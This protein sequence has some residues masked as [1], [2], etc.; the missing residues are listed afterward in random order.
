MPKDGYNKR[1]EYS[2][3][4]TETLVRAGRDLLTGHGLCLLSS[5][6]VTAIDLP[7]GDYGNQWVAGAIRITW[8]LAHTSG[9]Y[10][11]GTCDMPAIGSR[12]RPPDKAVSAALTHALGYLIRGLLMLERVEDKHDVDRRGEPPATNDSHDPWALLYGLTRRLAVLLRVDDRTAQNEVR[13]IA[14]LTDV[15]LKEAHIPAL[16]KAAGKLIEEHE[17]V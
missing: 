11:V 8:T 3:T 17:P 14:G 15:S 1:H 9:Q 16:E 12:A 4:T 7:K 5:W 2:Y 6:R 10:V 13:K